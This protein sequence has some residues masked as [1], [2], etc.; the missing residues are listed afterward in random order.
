MATSTTNYSFSLPEVGGDTDQ[1]GTQL[2]A[3]WTSLDSTLKTVADSVV[4][5]TLTG[6]DYLTISG[7]AI[8]VGDV[9]LTA[10]VTGTLPVASGGTGLAAI[11]SANQILAVNS[12][13]TAL[14][15]KTL[16]TGGTVTS[17][18]VTGSDGIEIDSG[19]PII[20]SGTITLGIN[21]TSLSTH[22]G[23]GSLATQSTITESQIS[24]LGSYITASSTDTLTNKSGNISQ[25]TNDSGYL[26]AETNDLTNVSGTLAIANGGTGSTTASD[27]RTALGVDPAGTDNSTDVTLATVTGNYL[28][29]SGQQITAGTVPV[30]LG[31]TGS[32]TAS[33]ARTALGVDPA[34][35]D[36]STDITL[37]TV[38]GNYLTLS[39]QEITAG[40]VPVSL[41][42][43]GSTTAS[44]A[45][46]ALGVDPSGTDN[47]TNVT[48][49]TVTS[50]YLTISGQEITAGTVPVSLGGTG[51]TTAS[52]ARTALGVDPAGTDNSTPVSLVTTSHDYLSLSSQA[53]TLG[54]ID[55]TAD[56]SGT[57]PVAN[58]GTGVTALSSLNAADLGSNNGVTDA[59]DGY[60]LTADGTGGVAWEAATGGSA[61][62]NVVEDLSPQLGGHLDVNGQSIQS[63]NNG[64]IIFIPDGTGQVILDGLYWPTAD[65]TAN[66]VL[67]TDGVGN[68]SFA[69]QSGGGGL[70]EHANS[71]ST[72][73]T[74]ASGQHRLYVGPVSF[75]NTLTIAGKVLIFDGLYNQAGGTANIT[76]TLHIRS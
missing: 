15:Y 73:Q 72:S 9:D 56:V 38:T 68:L 8:T 22:L 49:A 32:T 7:Q 37:A 54:P 27:A 47:S 20:S 65:G 76:G 17:V 43:T 16:S 60:V 33:D 57:L 13:G 4:D 75:S 21:S 40:T 69:D 2:N 12:G 35:T 70:S 50:N 42:G 10:D 29:L 52:D 44:D 25:W 46:T 58:G 61:I 1:W 36:N 14:E 62:S 63:T 45:R 64:H 30:T 59:T 23:L 5:V 34:G 26:T 53:I 66:Q 41:G 48:L 51:S 6:N 74:V 55:L 28:S 39:G 3:N 19:S 71:I 67:K 31:G 11:G 18:A 24:D